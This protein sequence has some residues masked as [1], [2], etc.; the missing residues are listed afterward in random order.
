LNGDHGR[1]ETI[2]LILG[3]AIIL[4]LC[5]AAALG[6]LVAVPML[7]GFRLF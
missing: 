4:C 7:F 5:L 1:R 6:S 2:A 3:G